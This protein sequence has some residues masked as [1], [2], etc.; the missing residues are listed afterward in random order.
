MNSSAVYFLGSLLVIAGLAYGAIMLGVPA[1][2]VGIGAVVLVGIA[3]MNTVTSTKRPS[4]AEGDV[5]RTTT[6]VH[7]E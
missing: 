5:T 7:E 3:L 1:L 6:T 2:W 4:S